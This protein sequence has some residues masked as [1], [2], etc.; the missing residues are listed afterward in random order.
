MIFPLFLDLEKFSE[1]NLWRLIVTYFSH[2]VYEAY[3]SHRQRGRSNSPGG[4]RRLFPTFRTNGFRILPPEDV[5]SS[6]SPLFNN[7]T[8]R[9][10]GREV[11]QLRR[12]G[13]LS[14]YL[15]KF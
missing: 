4:T 13:D 9:W 12:S 8:L 1:F 7:E 14:Y 15:G 2:R 10:A 6:S 11:T 3:L 5:P